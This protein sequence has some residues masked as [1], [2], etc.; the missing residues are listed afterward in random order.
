[1]R[2]PRKGNLSDRNAMSRNAA[3]PGVAA[4]E[5]LA[6]ARPSQLNARIV[7]Q[8][9]QRGKPLLSRRAFALLAVLLSLG[10]AHG[11]I[12]RIERVPETVTLTITSRV[13]EVVESRDMILSYNLRNVGDRSVS[14]CFGAAYKYD[15]I[16]TADV[17]GIA[18]LASH[19]RCESQF[20]FEPGAEVSKNITVPVP[21]VGQGRARIAGWVHVV[22]PTHC[23]RYCRWAT[24]HSTSYREVTVRSEQA[25][26]GQQHAA[27]VVGRR[28]R[29]G[30]RPHSRQPRVMVSVM[31][32][33]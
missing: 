2:R 16:G 25:W 8:T 30:L 32:T 3:Q 27:P 12:R 20:L 33:D 19:E 1:M 7:G 26:A 5:L 18:H 22:E 4:D 11:P 28:A 15:I 29:R 10:C 17:D 14:A 6:V 9:L 13:S 31:R 24:V 23:G 21:R